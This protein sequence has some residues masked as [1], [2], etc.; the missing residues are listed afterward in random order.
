MLDTGRSEAEI[1]RTREYSMLDEHDLFPLIRGCCSLSI[2]KILMLK[3]SYIVIPPSTR[4]NLLQNN[5]LR[6]MY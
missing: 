3:M 5:Y 6:H 1:P 2:F 4:G